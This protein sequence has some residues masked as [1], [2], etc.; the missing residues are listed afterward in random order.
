MVINL[1]KFIK[2]AEG[3]AWCGLL[4][5]MIHH[6]SHLTGILLSKLVIDW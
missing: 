5:K 2:R 6:E 1:K 3:V 4:E